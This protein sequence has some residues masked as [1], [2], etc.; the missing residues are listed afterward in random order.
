MLA[1]GTE[2]QPDGKKVTP[3]GHSHARSQFLQGLIGRRRGGETL[4]EVPLAQAT[5]CR[6]GWFRSGSRG[7][8]LL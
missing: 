6:L 8:S 2:Q 1:A 7:D 4:S 5:I 3:A